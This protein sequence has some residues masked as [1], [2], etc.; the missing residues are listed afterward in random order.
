MFMAAFCDRC[1]R[2]W[3]F[4]EGTGDSCPIAAD[5]MVFMP[6]DPGYPSEWIYGLDDEPTCTAFAPSPDNRQGVE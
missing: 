3:A 2:D 6:G 5:T 1:E 4:R